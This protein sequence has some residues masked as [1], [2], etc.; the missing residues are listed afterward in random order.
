MQFLSSNDQNWIKVK[1]EY[2]W[3]YGTHL[4]ASRVTF[5]LCRS[6]SQKSYLPREISVKTRF[7]KDRAE[8][9]GI[10]PVAEGLVKTDDAVFLVGGEVAP[11]DVRPEVVDPPQ[12]AALPAPPQPWRNNKHET[13]S[14]VISGPER[15]R[16]M[17]DSPA[18]LGRARQLGWP[19]RAM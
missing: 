13:H 4:T 19:W 5:F 1:K 12:P 16:E 9:D 14:L 2:V 11:L 6:R 7:Y 8:K 18:C 10:L 15:K 3:K 17:P